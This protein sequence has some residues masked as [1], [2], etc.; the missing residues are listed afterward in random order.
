MKYTKEDCINAIQ[1]FYKENGKIPAKRSFPFFIG[2]PSYDYIRVYFGSWNT[3][4]IEAGFTPNKYK[5]GVIRYTKELCIKSIQKFYKEFGK[6]PHKH[7]FQYNTKYPDESTVRRLFGTWNNA[8][9]AAGYTPQYS[10]TYGKRTKALDGHLYRSQLEARFVNKFLFNKVEYIIEPKYPEGYNKYYDWYLPE[11]DIYIELDGGC[12][13]PEVM[14]LKIQ[15]NKHL[16]RDLLVVESTDIIKYNNI[17]ELIL[18][19]N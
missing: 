8:I 9:E 1:R 10:E 13:P 6:I 11:L 7:E 18:S 2:C 14:K 17:E 12:R 19:S 5:Q 3:A 4:I 15:I 16:S